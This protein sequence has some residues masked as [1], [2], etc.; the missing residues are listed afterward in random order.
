MKEVYLAYFDF[1]GFKEFILNNKDEILIRRMNHIFRD[2]EMALGEG[3][4]QEPRGGKIFADISA[5]KLHCLN[6]SDTVLFWTNDCELKSLKEL[7][8]VSYNFNWREIGYNFPLRGAVIRGFIKEVSDKN[9][10]EKGGSY[11]IQCLY[12]SGLV[13]A[14]NLA[15]SQEWAGTLIDDS[16][17]EDLSKFEN[18][19]EYLENLA[20]QY[21]IPFKN[22]VSKKYYAFKLK[23]GK[24]SDEGLENLLDGV[25]DIFALDN[26]SVSDERVQLKIENTKEFLRFLKDKI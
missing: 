8:S 9:T 25:D 10:N 21:D 14:H 11:S 24:I 6:I 22:N 4:Y 12:G 7:L 19:I 3:K 26:K 16:I 2:I 1:M 15:E 13:R 5:S 18:G 23:Q 17:I 20:L